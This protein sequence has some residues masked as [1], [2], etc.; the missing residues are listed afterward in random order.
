MRVL[1]CVSVCCSVLQFVL[2][3][4]VFF[5]VVQMSRSSH[6]RCARGCVL[7]K[8]KCAEDGSKN[9]CVG[10]CLCVFVRVQVCL[11][12]C[13]FLCPTPSWNQLAA[14]LEIHQCL[15]KLIKTTIELCDCLLIVSNSRRFLVSAISSKITTEPFIDL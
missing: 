8:A 5:S 14:R 9:V 11:F 4:P 2:V 7:G 1:Q 6:S 3:F 12:L 15:A 13:V 10:V